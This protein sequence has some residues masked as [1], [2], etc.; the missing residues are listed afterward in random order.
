MYEAQT[1]SDKITVTHFK[2][3]EHLYCEQ[4]FSSLAI[5]AIIAD[6]LIHTPTHPVKEEHAEY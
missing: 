1:L 5:R 3:F 6:K 4:I 2:K